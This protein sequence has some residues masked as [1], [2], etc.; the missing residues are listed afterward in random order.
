MLGNESFSANFY[1]KKSS[2]YLVNPN[3]LLTHTGERPITHLLFYAYAR[4]A[5]LATPIDKGLSRSFLC[6]M[7]RVP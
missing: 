2:N 7:T 4:E 1:I 5:Y 6:P 3:N